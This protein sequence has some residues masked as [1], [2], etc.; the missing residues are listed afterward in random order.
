M[1]H[2]DRSVMLGELRYNGVTPRNDTEMASESRSKIP[3]KIGGGGG[4]GGGGSMA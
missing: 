4:G 3:K 1:R 2:D